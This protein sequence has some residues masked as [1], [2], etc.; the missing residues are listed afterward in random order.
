MKSET[1]MDDVYKSTDEVIVA[2]VRSNDIKRYPK[3]I[4]LCW[5]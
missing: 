3:S 1:R 4:T 2:T 5:R